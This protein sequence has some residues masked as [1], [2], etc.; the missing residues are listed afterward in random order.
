MEWRLGSRSAGG[1]AT[2][3]G[4]FLLPWHCRLAPS[5][6]CYFGAYSCNDY[7]QSLI[8]LQ[9]PYQGICVSECVW[10]ELL[11]FLL[12]DAEVLRSCKMCFFF[13]FVCMLFCTAFLQTA[14]FFTENIRL[15]SVVCACLWLSSANS[16]SGSLTTPET[17]VSVSNAQTAQSLHRLKGDSLNQSVVHSLC[18]MLENVDVPKQHTGTYFFMCQG[19]YWCRNRLMQCGPIYFYILYCFDLFF[20]PRRSSHMMGSLATSLITIYWSA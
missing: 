4:L 6:I 3:L 13:F 9:K 10:D 19:L 14:F 11:G 17:A 1:R 16:S 7:K 12:L 20:C 8:N 18:Q 15:F 2:E 5:S